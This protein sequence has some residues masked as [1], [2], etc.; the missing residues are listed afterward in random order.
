[1]QVVWNVN[2]KEEQVDYVPQKHGGHDDA[3][4]ADDQGDPK[5]YRERH[6]GL[7]GERALQVSIH[8]HDDLLRTVDVL[9]FDEEERPN[10]EK[11]GKRE[12]VEGH[13]GR[14]KWLLLALFAL[15]FECL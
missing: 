8:D 10:Q 11:N 4:D 9:S 14:Q 3:K 6:C 1:M 2:H 13:Q 15:H 5:D 7:S 12:T